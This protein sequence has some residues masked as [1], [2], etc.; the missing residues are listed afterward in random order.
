MDKIIVFFPAETSVAFESKLELLKESLTKKN[1]NQKKLQKLKAEMSI[2][3]D[4]LSKNLKQTALSTSQLYTTWQQ[5]QEELSLLMHTCHNLSVDLCVNQ[6]TLSA[7]KLALCSATDQ[8]N[9]VKKVNKIEKKIKS[10]SFKEGLSLENRKLIQLAKDLLN[11]AKHPSQTHINVATPDS[12]KLQFTQEWTPYDVSE[13]SELSL[14]LFEVASLFYEYKIQQA[15][16]AWH[17]LPYFAQE[18]LKSLFK[19]SGVDLEALKSCNSVSDQE[20]CIYK[21]VSALLTFS[22]ELVQGFSEDFSKKEIDALFKDLYINLVEPSA[23]F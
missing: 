2:L 8:K 23:N 3:S 1:L 13:C 10:L 19:K 18:K 14:E 16:V 22:Q 4:E 5:Q 6:L 11:S 7:K 9:I 17:Q 21:I 20:S 15:F 12:L